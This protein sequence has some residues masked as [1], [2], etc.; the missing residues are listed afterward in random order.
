MH[1]LILQLR[2]PWFRDINSINVV[3]LV[4]SGAGIQTLF[5]PT[6][7][8]GHLTTS[9]V[10]LAPSGCQGPH[11]DLDNLIFNIPPRRLAQKGFE[12]QRRRKK[13]HRKMKEEDAGYSGPG[14]W[15]F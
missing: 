6:Q 15:S 1:L 11:E 4:N 3:L 2:D 14:L 8:P 7:K 12:G 10:V 5:C 13:G 9:D